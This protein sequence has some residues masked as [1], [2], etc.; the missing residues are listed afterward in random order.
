MQGLLKHIA[1]LG[2]I[3]YVP[4]APGT[5]GTL[6]A[7]VCIL[8]FPLSLQMHFLLFVI[9]TIIGSIAAAAAERAFNQK[10]SSRIIIDEFAGFFIATLSVPQSIP[11]F[12]AAFILFRF[13]DILKPLMIRKLESALSSGVGVMADDILAG[14]YAN[15][16][17]Q[18]YL[19]AIPH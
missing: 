15:I 8:V 11:L 4:F 5:F 1:T 6:A 12:I 7:L 18:V 14:L 13:F 10:D 16:I 2:P 3:G 19:H 17:L 9:F